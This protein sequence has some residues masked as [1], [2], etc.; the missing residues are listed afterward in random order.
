MS[1][2]MNIPWFLLTNSHC[3]FFIISLL[4]DVMLKWIV[5]HTYLPIVE[6]FKALPGKQIT[7]KKKKRMLKMVV[8]T[9]VH[10]VKDPALS[11]VAQ[12]LSLGWVKVLVLPI[13]VVWVTAVACNQPLARELLLCPRCG[14]KEKKK[15]FVWIFQV[16]YFLRWVIQKLLHEKLNFSCLDTGKLS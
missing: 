15:N 14:Q 1:Y 4:I 12:V 9:V 13:A 5:L 10:C 2:C 6:I 8:P 7:E 16:Q 3:Y 11:L